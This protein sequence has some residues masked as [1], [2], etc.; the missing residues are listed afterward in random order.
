MRGRERGGDEVEEGRDA[1]RDLP[2]DDEGRER[3][4]LAGL[5]RERGAEGDGCRT[6]AGVCRDRFEAREVRIRSFPF[7][8]CWREELECIDGSLLKMRISSCM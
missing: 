4:D 5:A 7:G 3:R 8:R 1:E 2:E 6:L